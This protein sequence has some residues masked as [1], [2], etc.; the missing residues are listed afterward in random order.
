MHTCSVQ[1]QQ[2]AFLRE[3]KWSK[4]WPPISFQMVLSASG[5]AARCRL[6]SC[7]LIMTFKIK[8]RGKRCVGAKKVSGQ[9]NCRGKKWCG[10]KFVCQYFRHKNNACTWFY[11]DLDDLETLLS[12]CLYNTDS[13]EPEEFS[14]HNSYVMFQRVWLVV[15]KILPFK[16]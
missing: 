10:K 11:K 8:C 14:C 4:K 12:C 16:C 6:F 13:L 2:V 7:Y 15:I 5:G 3:M 9:K 1:A